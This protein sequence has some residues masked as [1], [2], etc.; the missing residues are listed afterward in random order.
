MAVLVMDT[1]TS[2]LAAAIGTEHELLA[3]TSTLIPRGHSRLLQPVLSD[4]LLRAGQKPGDVELIAVGVGPG[5]YTGVRMGVSTGKAMAQALGIPIVAVSSVF[6]MAEAVAPQ[7]CSHAVVIPL[8][9]ARRERAF[10]AIYRKQQGVWETVSPVAV[11][12]VSEWMVEVSTYLH[13]NE[14]ARS[15]CIHDFVER[16]GVLET[17]STVE[18][19]ASGHLSHYAGNLGPALYRHALAMRSAAVDGEKLHDVVPDYALMV[20]AEVKLAERGSL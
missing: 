18:F 19:T 14:S 16:Y 2:V 7:V 8:L 6:T 1:A 3:S 11:K 17:L 13:Q 12:P 5:S 10:G 15:Y 20:E 9:Y 4:L